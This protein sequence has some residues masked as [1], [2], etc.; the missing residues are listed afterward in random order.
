MSDAKLEETNASNGWQTAYYRN[1]YLLVMTIIL[2]FAGGI[3]SWFSLPKLEDPRIPQRFFLIITEYPGASARLVESSITVPLES[4]LASTAEIKVVNSTSSTNSSV[5]TIELD[6]TV[7]DSNNQQFISRISDRVAAA[8][9]DLPSQALPPRIVE[10]ESV[11]SAF[12]FISALEWKGDGPPQLDILN[13]IARILKERIETLSG[14]EYVSL[15]GEPEEEIHVTVN[16]SEI[17]ELGLSMMQ[18]GQ[19]VQGSDSKSAAGRLFQNNK[20][21]NIEVKGEFDSVARIE[22]LPIKSGENNVLLGEIAAVE[23]TH[24]QPE[25][26]ITLF[27]GQRTVLVASRIKP[28]EQTDDWTKKVHRIIDSVTD[29][30]GDLVDIVPVFKQS[31]YTNDR[32]SVL[33]QNLLLGMLAVMGVVLIFMGWKSGLIVA[34][35]LPLTA[36]CVLF[37]LSVF[38]VKIQ[39]MSMFGMIMAIGLLIDNAIVM[40]EEVRSR[41]QA[42]MDRITALKEAV[43]HLFTPLLAS[44]LT[45]ILAFMPILL[46]KGSSGDFIGT[47][48]VSVIFAIIFSY[49]LSMTVIPSVCSRLEKPNEQNTSPRWWVNGIQSTKHRDAFAT[50]LK[51]T[52]GKPWLSIILSI[53]LCA[54]GFM[55]AGTLP[56]VFFPAAERDM[57]E[58]RV[59]FEKDIS[60]SGAQEKVLQIDEIIRNQKGVR[61]T[62]W[63]IGDSIPVFYYNQ[64]MNNKQQNYYSE[65]VI[66]TENVEQSKNLIDDLQTILN[67]QYPDLQIV[68]KAFSQGPPVEAPLELRIF[69]PQTDTLRILGEEL[70][71]VIAKQEGVLHTQASVSGGRPKIWFNADEQALADEGLRLDDVARQLRSAFEGIHAGSILEDVVELPVRI[72]VSNQERASIEQLR[73]FPIMLPNGE[74]GP[75]A[76]F[77]TFS[78]TPE[79]AAIGRR[80]GERVNIIHGYL[81]QGVKPIDV[82]NAIVAELTDKNWQLPEGYRWSIGGDAEESN[83]ANASLKENLPVLI[84][85]MITSLVLAFRSF[86]MAAIIGIVAILSAGFGLLSLWISGFPIGFIPILGVT[87][88]IGI[89]INGSIVVLAALNDNAR[90]RAGD[91]D[92]IT[93]ETIACSR[94]ILSTTLTTIAGF[95]PLILLVGGQFWPP[96]AVVIA[97]GVGL[98]IILSLWFTPSVY[99]LWIGRGDKKGMRTKKV[100]LP[101]GDHA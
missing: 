12:T 14:T 41:I 10:E 8:A 17:A 3:S 65:V 72:S 84:L 88:L 74:W 93:E 11:A 51:G 73:S 62:V 27:N 6:E 7:D 76:A 85:L 96:L 57:F 78:I 22:Q 81:T 42:G 30:V 29:E 34:L 79:A 56:K 97:G 18:L 44:S 69:G 4:A 59:W 61:Q 100:A 82:T 71:G 91:I 52:L 40:T 87:G 67:D 9:R 16:A 23:R 63:S 32:L 66:T 80:N 47:I 49:A 36:G 28:T 86:R 90:A 50:F 55:L 25:D 39:Q 99:K 31:K 20:L 83:K 37:S 26:N 101:D 98:S 64:L 48:S 46:I 53:A 92:A 75:A 60:V 21:T 15:H 13:R 19:V 54:A 95:I 33:G 35:S 68:T 58:M 45:T 38:D 77:G 5:I 2:I 43:D 1:P 89:A 94:H 24:K 70:R